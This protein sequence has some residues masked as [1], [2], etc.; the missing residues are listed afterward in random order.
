M[1]NIYELINKEILVR[2]PVDEICDRIINSRNKKIILTGGRGVGKSV[3]L[4][5]LENRCLGTKNECINIHFDAA[6]MGSNFEEQF[7]IH[8]YELIFSNKLLHYIKQNYTITYNRYFNKYDKITSDYF[9]ELNNYV[10]NCLYEDIEIKKYLNTGELSSKILNKFK[11][12]LKLETLTLAIDRFDWT[13][14]RNPIAQVVLSKYFNMFDKT[15]ITS[16]DENV[17]EKCDYS[18][19]NIDYGKDVEIVKLILTKYMLSQNTGKKDKFP[20]DLIPTEKYFYLIEKTNGN[21]KLMLEIMSEVI[22]DWEWCSSD[23]FIM[24]EEIDKETK[25]KVKHFNEVMEMSSKTKFYL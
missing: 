3:V 20:F 12:V 25:Y 6:G 11:E 22:R 23:N 8:Y 19:I 24:N 7:Y 13:L 18:I 5:A 10:N 4:S 21:I 17:K 14:N 9:E 2:E 1:K 16:D 15:V